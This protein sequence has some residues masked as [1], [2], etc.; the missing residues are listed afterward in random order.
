MTVQRIGI[1]GTI[2]IVA[3]GTGITTVIKT[4]LSSFATF[5]PDLSFWI[6]VTRESFE[7][8]HLP[9][10][11]NLVYVP[12]I[13]EKSARHRAWWEAIG[14]PQ[15]LTGD[16]IDVFW[17]PNNYY[18]PLRSSV[19]SVLTLHD[20]SFITSP[21]SYSLVTRMYYKLR[22]S[23]AIQ[24]ASKILT[25]SDSVRAA[26]LQRFPRVSDKVSTAHLGPPTYLHEV[27]SKESS[28]GING[29]TPAH[30]Y[31]LTVG[32]HHRKNWGMIVQ[33]VEALRQKP[34]FHNL[35][36]V[37]VGPEH[38]YSNDEH[39]KQTSPFFKFTGFVS[40]Q[41]LLHLY[42]GAIAYVT[43]SFDEGFNMTLLEAMDSD[44]P[45]VCSDISVH[46][47]IAGNAA[48]YFD[49]NSHAALATVLEQVL[50]DAQLRANLVESG[51]E[52]LKRFSWEKCARLYFATFCSA[53][54]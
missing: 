34:A 13:L 22:L 35:Q 26:L 12:V 25:L 31:L 3:H 11:P 53:T 5:L 46:H 1:D 47:E 29:L 9:K 49:P 40:D 15:H 37:L 16:K 27:Q 41:V 10:S 33:A 24:A 4:L 50:V 7:Y 28:S 42:R 17:S 52:N 38:W 20:L 44:T 21:H 30:P 43:A 54:E 51:H 8:G 36:L 14:L 39:S 32:T 48:L 19:P 2:N 18:L 23:H 45:V 6:Y